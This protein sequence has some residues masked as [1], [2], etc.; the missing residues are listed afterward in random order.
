MFYYQTVPPTFTLGHAG[1]APVKDY[2]ISMRRPVPMDGE[3]SYES[4]QGVVLDFYKRVRDSDGDILLLEAM[5]GARDGNICSIFSMA[6]LRKLHVDYGV[7]DG[8][9]PAGWANEQR[10]RATDA[11]QTELDV[12]HDLVDLIIY[13]AEMC[14]LCNAGGS[15][16]R[17]MG[18]SELRKT[19][20]DYL[21]EVA[22]SYFLDEEPHRSAS[23]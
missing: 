15:E 4:I 23:P 1:M 7:S 14:R 9:L 3:T 19:A 11:N 13:R 5:V 8:L 20:F 12:Q 22:R 2:Y 6:S 17:A 16:T 21:D 18:S 10:M